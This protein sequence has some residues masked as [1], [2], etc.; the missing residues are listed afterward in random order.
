MNLG[1]GHVSSGVKEVGC[2]RPIGP[3]TLEA[4]A[5]LSSLNL[6]DLLFSLFFM[7]M[8]LWPSCLW[9]VGLCFFWLTG[10]TSNNCTCVARYAAK[11][12]VE[13]IALVKLAVLEPLA[14]PVCV[15]GGAMGLIKRSLTASGKPPPSNIDV[16]MF[17]PPPP[18]FSFFVQYV[19]LR[20]C[21]FH[22]LW[23]SY[24]WWSQEFVGRIFLRASGP[25]RNRSRSRGIC[26][27]VALAA[28]AR[29]AYGRS[30]EFYRPKP[31][32]YLGCLKRPNGCGL[33]NRNSRMGCPSKW[34]HGP[35]TCGLPLL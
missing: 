31:G 22:L 1:D 13:G 35:K 16:H 23:S 18:P 10:L 30:A 17:S 24:P 7:L 6:H 3:R 26:G 9:L 8:A 21:N 4:D 2:F 15:K 19:C 14:C 5:G 34:K 20:R 27:R 29:Q 25:R 11:R 32:N 28:D 33:K 12:L